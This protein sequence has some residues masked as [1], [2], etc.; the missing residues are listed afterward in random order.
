MTR[1]R[2]PDATCRPTRQCLAVT[3]YRYRRRNLQFGFHRFQDHERHS[4]VDRLANFD[5]NLLD[6]AMD[7][8]MNGM[9]VEVCRQDGGGSSSSVDTTSSI[10]QRATSAMKAACWRA[11]N[12]AMSAASRKGAPHIRRGGKAPLQYGSGF[13]LPESLRATQSIPLLPPDRTVPDRRTAAARACPGQNH[14][15]Q[16]RIPYRQSPA[17]KLIA[18]RTSMP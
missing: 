11:R 8:R 10:C 2:S 18:S 4:R 1:S 12:T 17:H 7:I 14:V 3:F 13:G 15:L 5:F 16:E 6:T 9:T